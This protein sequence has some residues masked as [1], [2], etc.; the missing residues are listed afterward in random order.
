MSIG[1]TLL[2][3]VLLGGLW[4]STAALAREPDGEDALHGALQV[5]QMLKDRPAMATLIID[6]DPLLAWTRAQFAGAATGFRIHWDPAPPERGTEAQH[7]S[8]DAADP[9]DQARILVHPDNQTGSRIGSPKNAHN[10]WA[11]LIFELFNIRHSQTFNRTY[12]QALAGQLSRD[13]WIRALTEAEH[14]AL[15][16]TARFYRTHWRVWM[17]DRRINPISVRWLAIQD[18]PQAYLEWI[19]RYTD[20]KGY[21]FADYGQYYR[22]EIAPYLIRSGLEYRYNPFSLPEISSAKDHRHSDTQQQH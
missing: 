8:A 10:L 12:R 6:D 11:D 7:R 17:R 15:I 22:D 13:D 18:V 16:E 21:P 9:D 1:R 19:V 4:L 14:Q 5:Q 3:V 20:P 2:V